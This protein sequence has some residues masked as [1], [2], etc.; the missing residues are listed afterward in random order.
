M[1]E[2]YGS[3]LPPAGK[4]RLL[5]RVNQP[6]TKSAF[7]PNAAHPPGGNV[8]EGEAKLIGGPSP[9]LASDAQLATILYSSEIS[10]F[11]V[12]VESNVWWNQSEQ[13]N[14]ER[15]GVGSHAC[16]GVKLHPQQATT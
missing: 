9:P 8:Y 10:A 14:T 13:G 5:Y 12:A 11:S 7:I 6:A 16:L 3:V 15:H 1:I 4:D 2:W